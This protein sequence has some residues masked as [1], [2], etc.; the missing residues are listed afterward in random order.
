MVWS[1][2]T[3]ELGTGNAIGWRF[4]LWRNYSPVIRPLFLPSSPDGVFALPVPIPDASRMASFRACVLPCRLGYGEFGRSRPL[5]RH[6]TPIGTSSPNSWRA[7]AEIRRRLL[8]RRFRLPS[9][10]RPLTGARR[11][12]ATLP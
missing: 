6:R 12:R 1:G 2:G 4:V 5:R 10:L 7:Y 9:M 8:G 3:A 11:P